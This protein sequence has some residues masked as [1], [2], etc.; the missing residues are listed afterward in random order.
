MYYVY[1]YKNTT[2]MHILV[3]LTHTQ[4]FKRAIWGIATCK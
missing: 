4:F 2:Y 1:M 3:L